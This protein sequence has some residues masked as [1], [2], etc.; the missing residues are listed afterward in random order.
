MVSMPAVSSLEHNGGTKDTFLLSSL[1]AAALSELTSSPQN[2]RPL[3]DTPIE[4]FSFTL[5]PPAADS[6]TA[7][8]YPSVRL[9]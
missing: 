2:S 3:L 7:E 5:C 1:R 6:Q 4:A 9:V 8:I